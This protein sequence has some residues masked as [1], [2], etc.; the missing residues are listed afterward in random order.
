MQAQSIAQSVP[1][2][3]AIYKFMFQSAALYPAGIITISLG[4][5]T[6]LDSI[7]IIMNIPI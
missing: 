7:V 1:A 5:G 2:I 6:K 3:N 4:K